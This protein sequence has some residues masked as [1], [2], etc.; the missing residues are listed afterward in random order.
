MKTR[1]PRNRE[2]NRREVGEGA[3]D[4]DEGNLKMKAIWRDQRATH[5]N[6]PGETPPRSKWT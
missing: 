2:A 6:F 5:A 1:N 3:S 4:G